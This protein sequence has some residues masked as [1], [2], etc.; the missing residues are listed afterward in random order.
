[1][2]DKLS[3]LISATHAIYNKNNLA[4]LKWDSGMSEEMAQG[5][6]ALQLL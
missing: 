6:T 5:S 2:E 3:I 1:M 4:S